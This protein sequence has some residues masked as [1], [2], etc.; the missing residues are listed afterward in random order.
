[1]MIEILSLS[2]E[3]TVGL[4]IASIIWERS[5]W[6]AKAPCASEAPSSK[7]DSHFRD[8]HWL[9][10]QSLHLVNL[11]RELPA[12]SPW[13]EKHRSKLL[14][15]CQDL[16]ASVPSAYSDRL[17]GLRNQ[18]YIDAMLDRGWESDEP[19][20]GCLAM[21]D[22]DQLK[23]MNSELGMDIGDR[24]I[25]AL[26]VKLREDCIVNGI[27][28][29]SEGGKFLIY[30]PSLDV[31]RSRA[32]VEQIRAQMSEVAIEAS[33]DMHKRS[34]SAS[35]IDINVVHSCDEATR[36]LTEGIFRA[37]SEGRNRGYYWNDSSWQPLVGEAIDSDSET[38]ETSAES[39]DP[40]TR[41]HR[42]AIASKGFRNEDG[43]DWG[44]DLQH[45]FSFRR[46]GRCRTERREFHR[47]GFDR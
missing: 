38:L 34:L 41:R 33:G 32:L 46:K 40:T 19:I 16:E 37:K 26:A 20:A 9:F 21:I 6:V 18:T 1:M 45:G 10:E 36:L 44:V 23:A 43:R 28:I 25:R 11:N 27:P 35:L 14:S 24:L 12:E 5:S 13:L 4:L 22:V 47:A 15:I 39:A 8:A 17:T 2:A 30:F 42:L 7:S 3:I 31:A 29:R